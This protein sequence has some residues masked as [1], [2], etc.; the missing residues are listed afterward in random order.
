MKKII[1]LIIAIAGF[2]AVSMAQGASASASQTVVLTLSNVM[3]ITFVATSTN[4][5]NVVNLPFSTLS[6]YANGIAS[7][8]QQLR[9]QSNKAYNISVATN[10][11]T[12]AYSGSAT[13][14]PAMPVNGVLALQVSQNGTGGNISSEFNG[15]YASLSNTP[16]SLVSAG[17]YGNNN[18][19]SIQ[20]EANPGINYP[21]GVYAANVVYTAS[22]P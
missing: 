9:I 19:L 13:P 2:S 6:Q 3:S 11:S 14:A 1:T 15:T 12:F 5:G 10:A 16:H 22:Q 18:T 20:Y 21:S 7:Q 17:G 4:T 8:P